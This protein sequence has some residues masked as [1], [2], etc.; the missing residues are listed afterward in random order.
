VTEILNNFDLISMLVGG[1]FGTVAGFFVG[2][3]GTVDLRDA[4][5]NT[6][7]EL[8]NIYRKYMTERSLN[9]GLTQELAAQAKVVK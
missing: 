1:V 5:D 4:L 6:S 8:R 2:R 7:T 9:E 3:S